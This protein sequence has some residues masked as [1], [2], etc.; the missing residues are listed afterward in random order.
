MKTKPLKLQIHSSNMALW[1]VEEQPQVHLNVEDFV[2]KSVDKYTAAPNAPQTL[3]QAWNRAT[4]DLPEQEALALKVLMIHGLGERLL[5]VDNFRKFLDSMMAIAS[6]SI[7]KHGDFRAILETEE[8][9]SDLEVVASGLDTTPLNK[10]EV[11]KTPH[12]SF[13]NV[14]LALDSKYGL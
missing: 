13:K 4:V 11:E 3:K 8:E 12:K 1:P 7:L 9:V 5:Q 6:L 10:H 14:I 2:L